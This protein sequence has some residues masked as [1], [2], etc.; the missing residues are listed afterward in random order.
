MSRPPRNPSGSEPGD[1]LTDR[2]TQVLALV[3]AGEPT[4]AI[5]QRLG[6]AQNTVKSHLTRIY[7]KTGSRNRVDAV[8]YYLDHYTALSA[9]DVTMWPASTTPQRGRRATPKPSLI[10]RQIQEIEARID[11]LKPAAGELERLQHALD[12]LRAVDTD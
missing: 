6:V 2:E 5:S 11:Q 3:A 4:A 9:A 7:N 8:R 10:E 1:P 12:A